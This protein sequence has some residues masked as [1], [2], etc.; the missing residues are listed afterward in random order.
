MFDAGLYDG[1]AYLCGYAVELA[2]KS[3]ICATL[4]VERYPDGR[5]G[6]RAALLTHDFDDLKLVAGL[7]GEFSALRPALLANWSLAS[8]WKPERRYEAKGTYNREEAKKILDAVGAQPDGVLTW[9][10]STP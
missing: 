5:K 1:C 3:R 9:L 8:E 2:L 10:L 7:S 4:G 6:V